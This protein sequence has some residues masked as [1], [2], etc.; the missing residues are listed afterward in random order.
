MIRLSEKG[1]IV[2]KVSFLLG[3][4]VGFLV[5]RELGPA[6]TNNSKQEYVPLHADPKS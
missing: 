4:A 1:H 5:D 2:K 3:L 6:R